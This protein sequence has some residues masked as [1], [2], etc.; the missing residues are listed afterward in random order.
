MTD[1][2]ET[3]L[4]SLEWMQREVGRGRMSRREFIQISM[5][6][7]IAATTADAMFAR[8]RAATPQKGGTLDLGISWGSTSNTLDPG[9]ILDSY[10]GTVN[11]TI[12][13]LLAQVDEKGNITTD[14]AESFEPSQ[15]TKVWAVKPRKG[16]TFHNGKDLTP[17]DV[18]ASVRHHMGPDTKS[19]LKASVKQIEDVKAD[20]DNVIFTLK[21]GNADFPYFLA[22]H[23]LSIMPALDNGGVDWQSGIGT[24]PYILEEF[25]PG[26]STKGKRNPNY[27]RDTWF[28]S[29]DILSVI[30]PTARTNALL[31]GRLEVMDRVDPKTL[32]FME[33]KPGVEIDKV[34]GYEH[35]TFAMN[36][37]MPPFDNRD[38]RNALKYAIDREEIIKRVFGGIGT[39]GNDN[40]VAPSVRFAVN[41]E[42][43]HKYDPEMAKSLLK[44]AGMDN[45]KVELSAADVAFTGAV[46][47]ATIYR[48]SAAKAGIDLTVIR[49]PNDGYWDNVWQKKAFVTSEWL[50]RPTADAVM[51]FEYAADSNQND[52]FWKNPRF[53]ELLTAARS[54]LD[55]KKRAAMYAECQQ[56]M[57]DD[58][59]V[60]VI[61]FTTFVTAH[62]A[63]VA[64]GP[65]LSSLDLDGFRIAQRW[66]HT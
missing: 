65:L 35:N 13:S 50:G 57:H 60:I 39:P 4:E 21:G 52:T 32:K 40:V 34:T 29:V 16:V 26:E 31:S 44:K 48:E 2:K 62:T 15:G 47:A 8:A 24:G 6:A 59:G 20:G 27:Y 19:A 33:Q 42:P 53:N 66:W 14:L 23:R 1:R 37:T 55:E 11:L 9:P 22:E 61:M 36:V 30:D 18:V 7:G 58:N 43:I 51:T 3:G 45:L 17:N 38:V 25:K 28:D 54:E 64:H 49:E 56:L 12:R 41:P 5:A 46:D 10:M 63:K